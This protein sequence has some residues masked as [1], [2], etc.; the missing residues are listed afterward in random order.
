[1]SRARCLGLLAALIAG[2]ALLRLLMAAELGLGIDETYM[3][4]AGRVLHL[5]YFDHP[6]LSW[7]LSRGAAMLL[8]SER[9]LVVRLPFVALFAVSTGL[10]YALGAL[11][12][13]PRAGLWAAVALN[14][15]PVL[16]ITTGFWVLPDGPLVCALLGAGY[17]LMR[18]LPGEDTNWGWWLGAGAGAG[19]A[20]LSKYSAV[21]TLAG[22]VL[23]LASSPVHRRWLARPQPWVA[24]ALAA[25]LF[26]PALAWNASEGWA[27]FAFQGGRAVAQGLHP[28]GPLLVLGGAALYL[29]P[30]IWAGLLVALARG[31]RA[32]PR[33]WQSW[34]LCCLALPPIVLFAVVAL[35]S[36]RVLPHWAVPGY[37][38]AFPLLG[39]E[40]AR[41]AEARPRLLRRATAATAA[42]L[43]CGLLVTAAELRWHWLGAVAPGFDPGL[44]ALDWTPLRGDL[45]ERG[46]LRRPGTVIAGASWWVTGKL[47]YALGG[48]PPVLCLNTDGREYNYA[49]GPASR[50]GE[51]ALLL[52]P[53]LDRARVQASYGRLFESID[54]LPPARLRFPARPAAAIPM[55]LGHRLLAWP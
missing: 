55:F 54:E 14:L 16:G 48:D 41:L 29:L 15:A 13:S 19:L 42:L 26:A 11:A 43:A 18:A 31:L 35:W 37:L 38:F 21:L 6:P 44:Q 32:G 9:P 4:A 40:L 47:D 24:A 7:W 50:L 28:A 30:W 27:S 20:L 12:G 36:H 22:A 39:A 34:L 33:A 10:V 1:M 2:T 23:Y 49:P 5:S 51:D 17:C 46:L 52:G 53:G 45:D 3:V 8:G 25:A